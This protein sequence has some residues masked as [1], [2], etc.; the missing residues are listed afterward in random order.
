MSV[1]TALLTSAGTSFI[2]DPMTEGSSKRCEGTPGEGQA[3]DL[4]PP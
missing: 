1:A 4:A 2:F 3:I